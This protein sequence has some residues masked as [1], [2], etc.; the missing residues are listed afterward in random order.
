ML[1]RPTTE[2]NLGAIELLMQQWNDEA[3]RYR[4]AAASVRQGEA[5]DPLIVRSAI[6]ARE[7]LDDTLQELESVLDRLPPGDRRV[8]QLLQ[9]LVSAQALAESVERSVDALDPRF[10]GIGDG[11]I[12]LPHDASAGL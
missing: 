10:A 5:P 4:R 12:H 11:T 7:S 2:T 8:A 3:D 1:F 6:E 9:I